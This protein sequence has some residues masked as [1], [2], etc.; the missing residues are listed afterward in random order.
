[1][2]ENVYYGQ[3]L[4]VPIS[5]DL[6]VCLFRCLGDTDG[7]IK[8]N[9]FSSALV[10]I[11]PLG[12]VALYRGD[13]MRKGTN[14]II[15]RIDD[16]VGRRKEKKRFGSVWYVCLR[17]REKSSAQMC[18]WDMASERVSSRRRASLTMCSKN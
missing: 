12:A 18:G 6:P 13:K 3:R 8:W 5:L 11:G 16:V 9:Y 4:K 2:Y 1:M 15:K 17:G 10:Y 7:S 14:S